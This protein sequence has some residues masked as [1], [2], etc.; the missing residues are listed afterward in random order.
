MSEIG[1]RRGVDDGRGGLPEQG[2]H[3]SERL[4]LKRRVPGEGA[5]AP[6]DR[7]GSAH[8]HP[9]SAPRRPASILGPR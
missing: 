3:G 5:G 2:T 6:P 4:P 1:R 7:A 8:V 9:A